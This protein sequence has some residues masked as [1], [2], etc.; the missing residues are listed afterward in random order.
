VAFVTSWP[1]AANASAHII[2]NEMRSVFIDRKVWR[3]GTI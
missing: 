2:P 3:L 1:C